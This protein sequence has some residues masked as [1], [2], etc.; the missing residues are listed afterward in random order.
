MAESWRRWIPVGRKSVRRD[1]DDELRFHIEERTRDLIAEGRTPEEARREAERRFGEVGMIRDHLVADDTRRDGRDRLARWVSDFGQDLRLALRVLS[2]TPFFA[3][4]AISSIGLGIGLSTTIFSAVNGVLL[5]ALPYSDADRLVAVYSK[6]VP[7]VIEGS[8]IG[9]IEYAAWRDQTKT[10]SGLGL[11]TWNSV[12]FSGDADAER[13]DGAEVTPNLFPLLGVTPEM[14]RTFTAEEGVEGKNR[15]VLLGHDLWQRRFGGDRGIINRT[16]TIDGAPW[17]VI[18]VMPAGFAFPERGHVWMPYVP[19]RSALTSGNRFL[20]GAIG[21]M[22]PGVQVSQVQADLDAVSMRLEQDDRDA[23]LDWR[24]QV[25]TIRQDLTGDLAKP[26]KIFGV[27]VVFLLLIACANVAGLMLARG[28]ARARELGVR[29]SLGGKRGRLLRQLLTE[30]LVL[31]LAGGLLGA[32]L[33][34]FGVKILRLAFPDSV[35]FYISLAVDQRA[36]LFTFLLALVVGL[37]FGA[38]P[39]WRATDLDL[40]SVVRDGGRG[41]EGPARSRARSVL[42]ITE[43]ALALVLTVG[44]ALLVR[45]YR[46]LMSTELGFDEQGILTARVGLSQ[47]RYPTAISRQAFLAQLFERLRALPNV[48]VVGS[49]Q[50]IPFSGWNVQAEF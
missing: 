23:N 35:P 3:I 4:M 8:N 40:S 2:R 13:I 5:R 7:R 26:L 30:S 19:D 37:L 11:W 47:A 45:S 50:G 18:G 29:A 43:V 16:V 46:A 17:T 10:L 27:A 21:R 20:A 49:A 44:G 32:W 6:N 41:G 31:A 24:P 22:A 28:A 25:M 42:V 36:L 15:V 38:W 33:S 1:V 34:T 48:E 39:A 14:G 12:A 9:W